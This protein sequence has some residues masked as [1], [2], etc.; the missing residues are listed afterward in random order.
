MMKN[1]RNLLNIMYVNFYQNF[2]LICLFS[3]EINIYAFS[4][5]KRK[6]T[7]IPENIFIYK[8]SGDYS[9]NAFADQYRS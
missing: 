1:N 6:N 9:R 7:K 2:S 5:R 8:N 4:K 3:I